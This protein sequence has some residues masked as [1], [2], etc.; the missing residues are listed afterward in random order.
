MI[1][2]LLS[3]STLYPRPRPSDLCV[4]APTGRQHF[5]LIF[6]ILLLL[7]GSGKTL[8]FVLPILASLHGRMVPRVRALAV[9]PTQVGDI[10]LLVIYPTFLPLH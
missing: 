2:R 5:L 4:A 7:A 1:P 6:L 10:L 8:A 3:L 9:L